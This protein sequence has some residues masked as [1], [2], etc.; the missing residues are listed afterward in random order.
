M[1]ARHI[2]I[3]DTSYNEVADAIGMGRVR[4]SNLAR[5]NVYPT[6]DELAA[7]EAFFSLPAEVLFEPELLRFRNEWPSSRRAKAGE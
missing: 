4:F 7:L 3:R 2:K 6:P 1:I 5:A